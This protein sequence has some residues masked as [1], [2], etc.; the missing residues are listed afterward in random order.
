LVSGSG[1]KKKEEV[2][3]MS[4]N[5]KLYATKMEEVRN[6]REISRS[7]QGQLRELL[8]FV[9]ECEAHW[10]RR[11]TKARDGSQPGD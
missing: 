1:A 7:L 10:E 6:R 5:Y 4:D 8:L 9:V 2:R 11:G 3:S